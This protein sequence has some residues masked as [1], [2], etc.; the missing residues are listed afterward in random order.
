MSQ[1]PTSLKIP[2]DDEESISEMADDLDLSEHQAAIKAL[3][4]GLAQYGYGTFA[5][6][7]DSPWIES[8]LG[9][10]AKALAVAGVAFALS[11]F[12]A[13]AVVLW[14]AAASLGAA[15]LCL[16]GERRVELVARALHVPD[17]PPWAKR[18]EVD[19]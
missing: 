16:L 5:A 18:S 10:V 9:E 7:D 19:E 8:I 11:I 1:K 3:Q 15:T 4:R 2:N 6:E 13:E 14:Y 17:Q 12:V